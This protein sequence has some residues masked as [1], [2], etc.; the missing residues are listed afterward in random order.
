MET[1]N[2]NIDEI[3][4]EP[5]TMTERLDRIV[6]DRRPEA[7]AD[8]E[9][10]KIDRAF[11]EDDQ[12]IQSLRRVKQEPEPEKKSRLAALPA[13]L[14]FL[15]A[16]VLVASAATFMLQ[17]WP[18]MDHLMR[19]YSFLG[20]TVLLTGAGFFCGLRLK[21]DKGAR[22][23]LATAAA[24]IP[25]HFAQLGALIYSQF[26]EKHVAYPQWLLWV[27]PS[28]MAAFATATAAILA[29]IPIVFICF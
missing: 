6:E 10:E 26:P 7:P 16:I 24:V 19:Y 28:K 15:G 29:L 8:D 21:E 22:T 2:L 1:R 4:T 13:L 17:S 5:L 18:G 11:R 23:F 20:F 9:L 12:R 14:R 27:A 25:V 3:K